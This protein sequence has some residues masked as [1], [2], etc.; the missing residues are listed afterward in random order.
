MKLLISLLM[1]V[2]SSSVFASSK[3]VTSPLAELLTPVTASAP[4]EVI[5]D[6]H[7]TLSIRVGGV[8]ESIAVKVG[9]HV[10]DGQLL[11]KL[12][13]KDYELALHLAESSLKA[14][15]AQSRLARQQFNRAER[16]LKQKNASRELR[17]QRR[18]ELDSLLA[19]QQGAQVQLDQAKLAVE[20]CTLHAPFSGVVT[21][22]LLSPG[23]L[24]APGSGLLRLL[25]LGVQEVRAELSVEQLWAVKE[26]REL[27]YEYAGVRY[28]I[29]LREALP[30]IDSR[31]RTQAV[32]FSFSEQA[33]LTGSSG[34]IYW[35]EVDGRLPVKYIVSRNGQLGV[36]VAIENKAEFVALPSAIEG[37]AAV[38]SGSSGLDGSSQILIE[39][40]H[41]VTVG[42]DIEVVSQD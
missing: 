10:K 27:Q 42:D 12:E 26:G 14:L 35:R 25:Q 29:A 31:A 37:Q 9:S 32:R 1:I 23:S 3:V 6:N 30:V 39:G 40:Q 36:M 22:L 15:Q 17:D 20:R 2:C 34:R 7:A 11:A 21:E 41:A 33:A 18:A 13:C 38:I 16:L 8:V 24:G 4:A 28:P 19:Q 5:N